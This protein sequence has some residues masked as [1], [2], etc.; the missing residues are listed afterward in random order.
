[1]KL[2]QNSSIIISVLAVAGLLVGGSAIFSDADNNTTASSDSNVSEPDSSADS[3]ENEGGRAASDLVAGDEVSVSVLLSGLEVQNEE[4]TDS[5][6]RDNFKHW[7]NA[8]GSGCDA[9]D[10]VLKEEAQPAIS[11]ESDCPVPNGKWLSLYDGALL[12]NPSKL[13][14]DHMVPLAEAWRSG[15]HAWNDDQREEY[16]N[17][18]GDPRSLIAVS[19]GS[20]RSK[21]DQDPD[22]WLPE[23]ERYL[24]TYLADWVAVKYRWDLSMET[25][26]FEAISDGIQDC[27]N[28]VRVPEKALG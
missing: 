16:A 28:T 6:D 21:S 2:S 18:M 20:N 13:D 7:T 11:T 17:D 9:R 27:E 1:M 12:T 14:I 19:A 24:C 5:Y 15:A 4:Q 10:A 3:T 25:S 26:E 23:D 22:E 8:P